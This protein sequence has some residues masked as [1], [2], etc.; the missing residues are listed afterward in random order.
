VCHDFED[1]VA[2]GIVT[3]GMLPVAVRDLGVERRSR[4]LDAFISGVVDTSLEAGEVA[5]RADLAEVLAE[6]R[7]F[8]YTNI[9][10]RP[11][12]TAQSETVIRVLRA[13]VEHYADRPNTLPGFEPEGGS[14]APAGSEQ[15]VRDAVTYVAGMTD[16]FAFACARSQ[17]GWE[18]DGLPGGIDLAR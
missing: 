5:M 11:A 8:N 1:A 18:V 3:P 10:M 13:L 12:S 15:A 14:G 2:A 4:Q 17:L 7:A 9:Y 6:F 16:R